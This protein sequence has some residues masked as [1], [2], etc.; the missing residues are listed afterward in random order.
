MTLSACRRPSNTIWARSSGS[1]GVSK[2]RDV[3]E[4]EVL[5]G[6][7]IRKPSWRTSPYASPRCGEPLVNVLDDEVLDGL[8]VVALDEE[9]QRAIDRGVRLADFE[10]GLV[11]QA[12]IA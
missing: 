4:H 2:W 6:K 12:R 11:A 3:R 5:P 10:P 8:G 9:I 7:C 1:S